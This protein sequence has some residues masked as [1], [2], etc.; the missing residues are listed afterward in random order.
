MQ[1]IF[2][3]RPTANRALTHLWGSFILPIQVYGQRY[4][5]VYLPY[6]SCHKFGRRYVNSLSADITYSLLKKAFWRWLLFFSRVDQKWNSIRA[7]AS[8]SYR[9]LVNRSSRDGSPRVSTVHWPS[10]LCQTWVLWHHLFASPSQMPCW[11][12]D[13]EIIFHLGDYDGRVDI[14]GKRIVGWMTQPWSMFVE[15][16]QFVLVASGCECFK[17]EWILIVRNGTLEV[18]FLI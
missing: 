10:A 13:R 1:N 14:H 15:L 9:D 6:S 16:L 11:P 7:A 12:G 18:L 3:I 5:K 4:C 8:S 17:S 2:N